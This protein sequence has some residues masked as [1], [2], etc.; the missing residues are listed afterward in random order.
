M[1]RIRKMQRPRVAWYLSTFWLSRKGK[2][3][4]FGFR[5]ANLFFIFIT[6]FPLQLYFSIQYFQSTIMRAIVL[7]A[8]VCVM[9]ATSEAAYT[10]CRAPSGCASGCYRYCQV[11]SSGNGVST[12][13]TYGTAVAT[14]TV[15]FGYPTCTTGT[16]STCYESDGSLC[17]GSSRE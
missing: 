14:S 15:S 1:D 8:F 3:C 16:Y 9:L 7:L 4:L 12:C 6:Y 11:P 2:I 13:T 5:E 10:K 17:G